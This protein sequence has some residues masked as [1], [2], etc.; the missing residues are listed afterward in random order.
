MTRLVTAV[1]VVGS[2]FAASWFALP[3]WGVAVAGTRQLRP[4]EVARQA[5][6]APGN[7]WLWVSP[8]RAGEL[9]RNP[10]VAR[11]EL[12]RRF[13]GR[14]EVR[15]VER[16][17]AALLR[18]SGRTFVV[19]ADGTE[20]PGAKAPRLRI[21]GWGGDRV[22]EA[23]SVAGMLSGLGVDEVQYSPLGFRVRTSRFEVWTDSVDSLRRHGAGVKMISGANGTAGQRPRVIHVYPW[24]V[25]VQQ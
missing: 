19:A 4:K 5:G 3:V 6:V 11:A 18:R 8:A 21:S 14:V 22:V 17:P 20:L 25:S 9:A 7:P 12:T 10:W 24:G 1:V 23:I 2:L 16:E 15:I 13:P